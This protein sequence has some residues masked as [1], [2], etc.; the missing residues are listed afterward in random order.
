[1]EDAAA[2]AVL[3]RALWSEA[4]PDAPG[5]AG[6]T[7]EI[8]DEL[9]RP[10]AIAQRIAGPGRHLYLGGDQSGW[11][12]FAATRE[13][14]SATCELA[15]ILVLERGSRRGLGIAL[16]AAAVEG[17]RRDGHERIVV[18]TEERN[19]RALGFYEASGF[20]RIGNRTEDVAGTEVAVVE[21]EM[22]L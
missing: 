3:L 18:H 10:E 11:L 22:G 19:E 20:R 21:L 13:A 12:G 14:G 4:G 16:L 5:F 1:M 8:I 6:T 9:T 7:D 15:G 2:V 17:A